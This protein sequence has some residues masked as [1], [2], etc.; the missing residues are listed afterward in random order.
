MPLPHKY[1]VDNVTPRKTQDFRG[2]C[3]DFATISVLEYT[4]RQ[5]GI[6][7]GWLAPDTYVSLSE[8]AYGADVLRLCTSVDKNKCYLTATQ[9]T[10]EGGFVLEFPLLAKDISIFPDAVC[11]YV[12][13]VG[14][15]TVCPGL[16]AAANKSNPLKVT[17]NKYSTMID[18]DDIKRALVTEKRC[19]AM[20]LSTDMAVLTHY[21]PCVGELTK[22]PRCDVASPQCTLCPPNSFQTACCIPVGEGVDSNIDGEFIAHYGMELEGGHAM[23]LV[24]Y[25]DNY[26]TQDGAT[27]GYILKN[28]W[29]DGVDPALGPKRARGS[30]SI[31]YWMQT[32]SAFEERAACPNSANPNNWYACQGSTGVIHAH[33]VASAGTRSVVAN[34]THDM[35]L[36]EETRLDAISQISPLKLRC[37][38]K[39]KCDPAL[40]YFTRNLTTVGDHFN[41][42]CVFEYNATDGATSHDV[43]FPPMLIMDVAHMI[44]PVPEEMREND[45]DHCGFYFYP[46]EKQLA[47]YQ[48][49][50]ELT[51]DNLDVT[52]APQS[53][54][55]NAAKFP[56]FDY[57]LVQASTKK[58]KP[59]PVSAPFAIV[60]A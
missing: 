40:T 39:T 47:Q 32:I 27:G 56:Q 33:S 25:N 30:H 9:N 10:T 19:V 53:Y 60:G 23:T 2:T 17:V 20:A 44:Q 42:L 5:Q 51:V 41:V 16:T 35:C 22:D 24:G 12:P 54:V 7:N 14:S 58:Q 26:R 28:S 46:Y 8:Q 55:A 52:W 21:Q 50:W 59:N 36:S 6:A 1:A 37:L 18:P 31:R 4:Y 49:G 34:A 48:R 15:D 38:D 43:C 3:W 57:S 13:D 29:W 11:P 45:P